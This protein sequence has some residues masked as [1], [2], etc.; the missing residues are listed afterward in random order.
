MAVNSANWWQ[1]FTFYSAYGT[2]LANRPNRINRL[3]I[4]IRIVW[5]AW[6]GRVP[7]KR[8]MNW[9]LACF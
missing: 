8:E 6:E 4:Q 7:G 2:Y 1:K 9:S 3:F 5:K